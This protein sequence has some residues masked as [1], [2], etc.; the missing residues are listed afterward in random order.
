MFIFNI[1]NPLTLALILAITVFSTRSKKKLYSGNSII[2]ISNINTYTWNPNVYSTR[3]IQKLIT[4]FRK[5]HSNRFCVCRNLIF[6]ILMGRWYRSKR[7]RD[8][9]CRY[10]FGLVL[11]KCLI[12][13]FNNNTVVINIITSNKSQFIRKRIRQRR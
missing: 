6:F 13:S 3:R 4:N 7:K 5:M 1:S 11:E 9:K 8:K 2:C 10:K 12:F